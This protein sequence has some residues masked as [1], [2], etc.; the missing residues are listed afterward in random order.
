MTN[1]SNYN[2]YYRLNTW[3][4]VRPAYTP[5]MM[6]FDGSTGYYN[7]AFTSAGNKVTAVARFKRSTF[8]GGAPE[9]VCK[10]IGPG[11]HF[12]ISIIVYPSDHATAEYSNTCQM[13]VYNSAGSQVCRLISNISITD[14]LSHTVFCSYDGDSG[15]GTLI[16]DGAD[17][18]DTG[19]TNRQ[20]TTGTLDTGASS[21]AYVGSNNTPALYFGGQ[22]GFFGHRDA[23]L[24]NWS[25]FM[26][27][28][29]SVK[30][31]DESGWTEW[32]AQPLFWNP[33]GFM[34]DN[35]GSAANMTKTG[36]II[37]GDG[38]ST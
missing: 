12:R 5:A 17:A 20:L 13:V 24:T 35:R 23:Y 30:E 14:D 1:L 11:T 34:E 3:E 4:R 15:L 16:I 18:D 31:L 22:I 7:K 38:G 28:D 36:T 9:Y 21:N 27:P 19:K 33:Y 25:D 6:D 29:G 32:G 37:V 2:Q 8:T 26:N 10:V